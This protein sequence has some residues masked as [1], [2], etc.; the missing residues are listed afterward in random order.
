MGNAISLGL[1][2]VAGIGIILV[3]LIF[4]N[5]NIVK[6]KQRAQGITDN[7]EKGDKS[8]DFEYMF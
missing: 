4:R 2:A 7:G 1:E 8:L 6:A 5:R 3:Y